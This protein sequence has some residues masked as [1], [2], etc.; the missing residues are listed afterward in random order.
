MSLNH[1][2]GIV[3]PIKSPSHDKRTQH[4]QHAQG[5]PQADSGCQRNSIFTP[6]RCLGGMKFRTKSL[7]FFDVLK[8]NRIFANESFK[9]RIIM[10]TVTLSPEAYKNAER[11]AKKYHLSVDDWVNQVVLNVFVK[12]PNIKEKKEDK[13]VGEDMYSWDEL[14]GVFASDKSDKELRD[15]YLE[16]KYRV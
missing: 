10:N 13:K 9:R 4:L 12:V 3:S 15:E 7:A 5:H 8:N 1:N 2:I 11:T 6:K 16:E 14:C